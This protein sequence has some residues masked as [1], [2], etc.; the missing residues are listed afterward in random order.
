MNVP[1]NMEICHD[2]HG[3]SEESCLSTA[4]DD[5]CR[6]RLLPAEVRN[7]ILQYLDELDLAEFAL[8]SQQCY[9]DTL[10]STTL[11]QRRT[12]VIQYRT[13]KV[14]TY[15]HPLVGLL[16]KFPLT[17]HKFRQR[18][19]RIRLEG[20]CGLP[21]INNREAKPIVRS[22]SLPGVTHLDLSSRATATNATF[23]NNNQHKS[24]IIAP[25]I[26]RLWVQILPN[27]IDLDLSYNQVGTATL[28]DLA[29]NG[30][31]LRALRLVGGTLASSSATLVDIKLFGESNSL[32]ELYLQNC[33]V[34]SSSNEQEDI[35]EN[36]GLEETC[37]LSHVLRNLERLSVSGYRYYD[38]KK[39]KEDD[40]NNNNDDAQNDCSYASR[41]IPFTQVSL[42]KI[43]R[44]APK[45]QWFQSDLNDIH[46][47]MLQEERPDIV[48]CR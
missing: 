1:M 32:R 10:D 45:L 42:I 37:P 9:R 28:A 25:S 38:L 24:P 17:D 31:T 26:V 48:F 35:F 41:G 44:R 36:E 29:R 19:R 16:L 20:G 23:T 27:L 2:Y 15:M 30:H 8:V 22:L 43:V 40:N 33:R 21:K 47:E 13:R 34:A 4:G 39:E 6:F 5:T 18:F 14:F 46:V 12:A 7:T 11:T 3:A